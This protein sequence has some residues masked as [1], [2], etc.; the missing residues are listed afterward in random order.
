MLI[1][2]IDLMG[3]KAVQLV[4]GRRRVLE[5]EDVE[6]LARRFRVYGTVAVVDLDA[7]LGRG[8]NLPLVARLCRLARCRVGGG[9]RSPERAGEILRLGADSLVVGTAADPGF[10]SRL[11]RERTWVALDHR[12]GEVLDRGWRRRTGDAV[13]R[14]MERLAPHCAGFLVTDVGREG[15][16]T[17]LD[18]EAA[19][20]WRGLCAGGLTVAGGVRDVAEVA[21]LDRLG[22]DAQV[23]MALYDGTLDPAEAFVSC[24]DFGRSGGLLPCV[25][26]DRGGR[27]RM[28][29]WQTPDSLRAALRE[30]RGVY[31]SRSRREIWRKGDTS[32]H[33]QELREARA[34]CD[35]DALLFTVDQAGP[36]CHT[37]ADTCFGRADFAL[38]DLAGLLAGR[39]AR[40]EGYTGRLFGDAALRRAKLREETEEVLEASGRPDDL[41]WECA[42]LL[43][44]L[45]VSMTAG[46]VRLEQVLSELARRRSLPRRAG[47]LEN[48][49]H[50]ETDEVNHR[51]TKAYQSEIT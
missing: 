21:E 24:L 13:A 29:A 16:L 5:V 38:A 28:L 48:S 41:V 45:L 30:G 50:E 39:A 19:A 8:D 15:R 26:Q 11:P 27:V 33:R 44:F 40:P 34:D 31:W 43:Y 17:G 23:G 7:A 25:V 35:R 9:I 51:G 6:A 12:G 10:L 14:R 22:V 37:G 20:R 47:C 3:G 46:G 18:R 2:S 32:G 1:P 4:G 42:D 36:A 49:K